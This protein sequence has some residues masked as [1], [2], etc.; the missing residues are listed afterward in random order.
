MKV[1]RKALPG[2]AGVI[3][4]FFSGGTCGYAP[5]TGMKYDPGAIRAGKRELVVLVK[6]AVLADM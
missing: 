6:L 2:H 4:S 3:E 1:A 5:T